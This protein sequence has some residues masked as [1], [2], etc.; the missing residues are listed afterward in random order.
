MAVIAA[1][2][3]LGARALFTFDQADYADYLP[4]TASAAWVYTTAAVVLAA[5]WGVRRGRQA[6][7]GGPKRPPW[8]PGPRLPFLGHAL[9]YKADPPGFLRCA[10]RC[11]PIAS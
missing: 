8:A 7:N 5:A 10:L 6:T 3:L 1:A 4:M 11:Y 2:V 9:S